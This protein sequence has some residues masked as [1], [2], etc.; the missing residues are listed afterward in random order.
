[1]EAPKESHDCQQGQA[2]ALPEGPVPFLV[3]F[4]GH[5]HLTFIS[6][7]GN[8]AAATWE[9]GEETSSIMVE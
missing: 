3:F 1:M 8:A 5:Y 7:A 2:S 4:S 6:G 9:E